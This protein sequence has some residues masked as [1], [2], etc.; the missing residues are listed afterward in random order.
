MWAYYIVRHRS[1]WLSPD[2][3][4]LQ[5]VSAKNTVEPVICYGKK[6]L[7]WLVSLQLENANARSGEPGVG[8]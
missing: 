5:F 3:T 4:S 2:L 7:T 8:F 6:S 1:Q